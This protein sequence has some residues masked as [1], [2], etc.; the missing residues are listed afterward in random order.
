MSRRPSHRGTTID[1]SGFRL[2]DGCVIARRIDLLQMWYAVATA[3]HGSIRRAAFMLIVR[4]PTLSRKIHD[5]EEEI[6]I[7][8]FERS[9]GGAFPTRVG[10]NFVRDMEHIL[11]EIDDMVVTARSIGRGDAGQ[12]TVGFS[13][14]LETSHEVIG[15]G[16]SSALRRYC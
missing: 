2:P 5:L 6:G 16:Q 9:T 15:H 8:L 3:Q 11:Q 1:N 10:H 7:T 12:L 4:Q 13:T 14:S